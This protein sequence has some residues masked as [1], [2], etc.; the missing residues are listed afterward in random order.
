MSK[1]LIN[2]NNGKVYK[3]ETICEYDEG[4][5]YIGSTTKKY[6]SQRLTKHRENY[7][8]YKNG[9]RKQMTSFDLFDK[10]GI[11][12][13][14]IVL[15]EL[16]NVNSK[17]ELHQREAHYIRTLK[18]VNKVI[19]LRTSNEYIEDNKDKRKQY[20]EAN[21]DKIALQNKAL[22]EANKEKIALQNKA[23][24][25]ANREKRTLQIKAWREANKEKIALQKKAWNEDNREKRAL[26]NKAWKEANKEKIALQK[27]LY[28]QQV[29]KRKK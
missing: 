15:L 19:P 27:K 9:G 21:K 3:I 2:Y 29:I 23:W 26:Q 6:L 1:A 24:Y 28:Y 18:C 11:D 14:Q 20:K 7:N 16:V 5:I 12:N 25:E 4:D 22:K 8:Q 10:Y 13:C 17:E